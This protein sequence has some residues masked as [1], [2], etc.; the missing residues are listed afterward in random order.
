[1]LASHISHFEKSVENI[2][3]LVGW[4]DKGGREHGL[5]SGHRVTGVGIGLAYSL[6]LYSIRSGRSWII[7]ISSSTIELLSQIKTLLV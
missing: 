2:P 7:S 5:I 3:S 1:M 6:V 4:T